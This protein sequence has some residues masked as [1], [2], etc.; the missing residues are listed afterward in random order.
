[1]ENTHLY[2][3]LIVLGLASSSNSIYGQN[4]KIEKDKKKESKNCEASDT[5]CWLEKFKTIESLFQVEP[6]EMKIV[7][8]PTFN[9]LFNNEISSYLSKSGDIAVSQGYAI[10]DQEDGRMSLGGTIIPSKKIKP[11][12]WVY[13]VGIVLDIDKNF[14]TILDNDGWKDDI[15]ISFKVTRLGKGRLWY[16]INK[17]EKEKAFMSHKEYM[18]SLRNMILSQD[19]VAM[20]NE[21]AKIN[22]L[23][24]NSNLSD[25]LKIVKLSAKYESIYNTYLSQIAEKEANQL[26][27][28]KLFT[29][30][31][32]WWASI[33]GYLPIT[34]SIAQ[35]SDSFSAPTFNSEEFYQGQLRLSIG[36][37][38]HKPKFKLNGNIY[39]SL[40]RTTNATLGEIKGYDYNNY[41]AKGGL[42]TLFLNKVEDGEK[43]FIGQVN[44][45]YT[46]T[47]GIELTAFIIKNWFGL[48]TSF[49][50]I[51]GLEDF[52]YNK[53]NFT[54][55]LVLSLK[56]KDGK[57][58]ANFQP[59]Y[60]RFDGS[61]FVGIGVGLPL[62]KVMYK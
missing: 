56:D 5:N 33:D 18:A 12:T 51:H 30:S 9:T 24:S 47:H 39:S 34:S 7:S 17:T 54:A 43:V 60:R 25:S 40:N 58:T 53:T 23:I 59:Q 41:V 1:M 52:E 20:Y 10:L 16:L 2:I 14:A 42:D 3:F 48:T 61:N 11:I 6:S 28:S 46:M 62:G 49:E 38:L 36:A 15:G 45:I 57:P 4:D 55:G 32:K 50:I 44:R 27:E 35:F 37:F 26:L 19:T 29:R 22:K 13:N 21:V 31:F 8:N